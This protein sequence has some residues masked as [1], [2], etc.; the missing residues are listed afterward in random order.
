LVIGNKPITR[1]AVAE[2]RDTAL[3]ADAPNRASVTTPPRPYRTAQVLAG[4]HRLCE[5]LDAALL[6]LSSTGGLDRLPADE[7]VALRQRVVA[8]ATRLSE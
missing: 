5:R 2:L 3:V 8:L 6:R 4:A 7:R 1:G